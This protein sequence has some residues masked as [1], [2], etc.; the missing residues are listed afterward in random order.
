MAD[1]HQ[2]DPETKEAAV[3]FLMRA[4]AGIDSLGQIIVLAMDVD[5]NVTRRKFQRPPFGRPNEIGMLAYA[6]RM[7]ES[8]MVEDSW[9]PD[10]PGELDQKRKD[11]GPAP[12][13]ESW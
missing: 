1:M 6:Q 9:E 11:E 13:M 12:A 3:N 2:W 10:D 5:G 7:V 4:A 8:E